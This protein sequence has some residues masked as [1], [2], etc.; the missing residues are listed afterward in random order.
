M[1]KKIDV[2]PAKMVPD[3]Q[4]GQMVRDIKT[5]LAN[6]VY[7]F[8]LVG[9]CYNKKTLAPAFRDVAARF[10]TGWYKDR[11]NI[12]ARSEDIKIVSY[13]HFHI[14]REHSFKALMRTIDGEKH[15]YVELFPEEVEKYARLTIEKLK[16]EQ[17]K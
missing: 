17:G 13:P 14:V 7:K 5:A 10:F 9:A 4:R 11:V 8:E 12:L 3:T 1:I 15:V 2:M 6:E 16:E